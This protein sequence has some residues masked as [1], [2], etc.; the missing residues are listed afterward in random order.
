MEY[1]KEFK[2]AMI[3]K[4]LLNPGTP[5]I[6]FSKEANI[7]NSPVA[8]W[9]RNYKKRNGS[10]VDSKKKNW[11]AEMKFQAVLE[12]A[13]LGEAEKNEY[14]RQHGLYQEQ[15]KEWKK[16]CISGC[17]KSPDQDYI[18]KAKQKEQELKRKTKVL[19]KELTRKEKALAEAAALL[20][21]KKKAQEIWGETEDE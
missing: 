19:E 3:Q 2:A 6:N 13:S 9:L 8:T 12:T 14:C 16:D 20:V 21:L 15:L 17:R 5:M 1:T 11:S 7:P 10:T 18:K 4:I